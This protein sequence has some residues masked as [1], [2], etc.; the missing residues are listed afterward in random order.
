MLPQELIERRAFEFDVVTDM[1]SDCFEFE[2]YRNTQDLLRR[3]RRVTDQ[4]R[5][6]DVSTYVF[7]LRVPTL[8]GPGS[9]ASETVI[10]VDTNVTDYPDHEP[11]T[12]VLSDPIPWSPHFLKGAPVCIGPEY[13]RPRS[14]HVTLGHLAIHLCR[15][16]NWDEKGRG[17]GYSGWN[18]A[19][20]EYHRQHYGNASLN[21]DLVYPILPAWVSGRDDGDDSFEVKTPGSDA[22]PPDDG[23]KVL[24]GGVAAR[25]ILR[26]HPMSAE[27]VGFEV[28]SSSRDYPYRNRDFYGHYVASRRCGGRRP[29]RARG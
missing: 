11:R 28:V 15:L 9:F 2:A 7:I 26:A 4:S 24:D 21:A 3:Q 23:F 22:P 20:I 8:S 25:P 12:S 29:R 27:T 6:G 16:L 13:W 17:P 18:R 5:G 10:S 19:A 1:P 14:G